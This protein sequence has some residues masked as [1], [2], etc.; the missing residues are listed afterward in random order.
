MN[1]SDGLIFE[2]KSGLSAIFEN[3]SKMAERF[4]NFFESSIVRFL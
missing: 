3:R 1:K 2:E 4:L